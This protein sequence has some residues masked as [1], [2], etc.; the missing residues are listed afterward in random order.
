[1]NT[2]T[3]KAKAPKAI[4]SADAL[5]RLAGLLATDDAAPSELSTCHP[6]KER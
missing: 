4:A 5:A 6:E 3:R 1:M 2:A